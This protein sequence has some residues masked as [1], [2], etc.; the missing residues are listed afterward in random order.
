MGLHIEFIHMYILAVSDFFITLLAFFFCG[1]FY[2]LALL[3]LAS[4]GLEIASIN[5][6]LMTFDD[7]LRDGSSFDKPFTSLL[8]HLPSKFMLNSE[9][10][11][12]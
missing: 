5:H 2:I 1:L 3:L 11:Y 6:D 8:V 10:F 4:W 9:Y 7:T 12:W